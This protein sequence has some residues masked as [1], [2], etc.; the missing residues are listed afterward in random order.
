M[1]FDKL[2]G[3]GHEMQ[4][5]VTLNDECGQVRN[6]SGK[7]K[8]SSVS[9]GALA[10]QGV[11]PTRPT[12]SDHNNKRVLD[13]STTTL[14]PD[15]RAPTASIACSSLPSALRL[16]TV[17]TSPT[18]PS[19]RILP[20]RAFAAFAVRCCGEVARLRLPR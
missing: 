13:V 4:G 3:G 12:R 17:L 6:A 16:L 5:N 8:Q 2:A 11:S 18:P 15:F 20:R 14:M 10:N 19:A 7:L 9:R 1:R